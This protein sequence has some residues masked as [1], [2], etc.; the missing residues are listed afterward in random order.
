MN[1]YN[2]VREGT[3]LQKILGERV[4]AFPIHQILSRTDFILDISLWLV[5]TILDGEGQVNPLDISILLCPLHS[6]FLF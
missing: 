2:E 3:D 1:T 6:D 5:A 4:R